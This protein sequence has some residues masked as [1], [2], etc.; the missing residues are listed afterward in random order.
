MWFLFVAVILSLR[1]YHDTILYIIYGHFFFFVLLKF[2]S[3]KLVALYVIY[4]LGKKYIHLCECVCTREREWER[5][6][7]I[8]KYRE[9]GRVMVGKE[10]LKCRF[11]FVNFRC[12]SNSPLESKSGL[13]M[14]VKHWQK[15]YS[16]NAQEKK[17]SYVV[18]TIVNFVHVYVY[19]VNCL[20]FVQHITYKL[21]I[22]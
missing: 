13:L 12:R 16:L 6:K 17:L 15:F 19:S 10:K 20:R 11:L 3:R 21:N 22:A 4:V 7:E 2:I 18:K 5:E 9:R 8:Q 1:C 14:G